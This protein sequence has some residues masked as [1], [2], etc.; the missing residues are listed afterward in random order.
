MG[1]EMNSFSFVGK[2]PS[3]RQCIAQAKRL[4]KV[5]SAFELQWGENWLQLE[6]TNGFWYGYGHIKDIDAQNIARELNN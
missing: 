6:K 2:K 3:L 1:L 5:S 4:E